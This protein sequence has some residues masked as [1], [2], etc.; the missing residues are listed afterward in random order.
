MENVSGGTMLMVDGQVRR[1]GMWP[2]ANVGM[3][4]LARSGAIVADAL[5]VT[6][7]QTPSVLAHVPSDLLAQTTG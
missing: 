7:P 5:P 1:M 6:S 4:P 3:G 2:L